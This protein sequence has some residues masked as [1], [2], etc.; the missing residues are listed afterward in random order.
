M[1]MFHSHAPGEH[2]RAGLLDPQHRPMLR[3]V[4]NILAESLVSIQDAEH[5]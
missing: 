2:H 5:H 3:F 4:R 1:E